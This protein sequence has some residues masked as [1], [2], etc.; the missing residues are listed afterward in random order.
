MVPIC[1]TTAEA[2][3]V[4]IEFNGDGV[5]SFATTGRSIGG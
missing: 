3:S 2:V 1:E 4:A 5:V